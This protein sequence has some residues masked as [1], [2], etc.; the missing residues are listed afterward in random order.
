MP[1]SASLPSVC[2]GKD[3]AY[4]WLQQ[5][6]I[7][8]NDSLTRFM[9]ILLRAI[10]IDLINYFGQFAKKFGEDMKRI[11]EDGNMKNGGHWV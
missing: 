6:Y 7:S 9:D 2:E 8:T 1:R 3:R 11:G 5:A 4:T 10:T